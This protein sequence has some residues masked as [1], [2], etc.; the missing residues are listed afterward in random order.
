MSIRLEQNSEEGA[1][2]L[3]KYLI[4]LGHQ[5]I[6]M[7]AGPLSV[8]TAVDR[9]DGFCRALGEA[10]LAVCDDQILWGNFTQ[11]SGY[12]NAQE[13]LKATQKPTALFAAN[14]FLAIGALRV[15]R[16][17]KHRVP[18]DIAVVTIDD[19]PPEYTI[20]PF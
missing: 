11:E 5:Q 14:N 19:I 1:Y 18:E 8:S 12:E 6:T 9:A 2:Q 13:A 10:G 7:L 20:T 4:S 16:E 15:L 3:T 17:K